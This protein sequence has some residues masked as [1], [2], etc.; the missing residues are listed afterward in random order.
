MPSTAS[1]T[2]TVEIIFH[3]AK[4]LPISDLNDLSCDPYI[5][6][7]LLVPSLKGRDKNNGE[8]LLTFRTPTVRRSRHAEWCPAA[9]GSPHADQCTKGSESAGS[10]ACLASGKWIVGGVPAEGFVLDMRV[11]DEDPGSHDDRLGRATAHFPDN[12][13]SYGRL[14]EGYEVKAEW[15]KI[16]RSRASPRVSALTFFAGALP[17]IK[18]NTHAEVCVSIRVLGETEK[19]EGRVF[20]VGPSTSFLDY[21]VCGSP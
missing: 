6:A 21:P 12:S 18:V 8:P 15:Y 17:G 10:P 11:R 14:K 13:S 16:K 4:N 1:T 7:T 2:Y 20:T 3:S 5:H 9:G 19:A